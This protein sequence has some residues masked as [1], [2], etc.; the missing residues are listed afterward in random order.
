MSE[1]DGHR[2]REDP[3]EAALPQLR[4]EVDH[5]S[6]LHR[7]LQLRVPGRLQR[8]PEEDVV[9]TPRSSLRPRTIYVVGSLSLGGS[10]VAAVWT[11]STFI[12]AVERPCGWGCATSDHV[13]DGGDVTAFDEWDDL[14]ADVPMAASGPL[15][16]VLCS[17]GGDRTH[18]FWKSPQALPEPSDCDYVEGTDDVECSCDLVEHD[19]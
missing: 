6:R 2:P 15:L 9:I 16:R 14:D 3:A 18:S 11:G 4:L 17:S 8:R 5:R 12:G 13:D 19:L 10:R 7:V 1:A